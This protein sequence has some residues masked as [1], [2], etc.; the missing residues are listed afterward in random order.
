M[1][2]AAAILI[3]IILIFVGLRVFSFLN[4]ER[5]LGQN[6]SDVETRLAAAKSDA[7][8]LQAETQYLLN[9]ANLEKELRTE[10][11]YKKPG[12]TMVI[13]VPQQAQTSTKP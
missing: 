11:N 9:P 7:A 12:E 10:F 8:D 6:L 1:K 3:F 13:I 2:L 5:V 4:E